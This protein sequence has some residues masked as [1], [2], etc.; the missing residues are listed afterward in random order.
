M[1]VDEVLRQALEPILRDLKRAGLDEPR[2][3]DRDW[4][5]D[6]EHPSVMLWSPDGSGSG[7]SVPRAATAFERVAAVADQV[8][9]WAIEEL[10]GHT[11]TN[12]PR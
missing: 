1:P 6:P 10:S 9:E 4:T 12:W 2:I 11:E 7:I 5:G 8:Q 3:E